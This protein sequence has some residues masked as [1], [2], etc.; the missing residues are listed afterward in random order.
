MVLDLCVKET[1]FVYPPSGGYFTEE[2]QA[3]IHPRE[4][5]FYQIR[6]VQKKIF[7]APLQI[8]IF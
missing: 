7:S 2:G 8:S 3:D 4:K 1:A 6:K 5:H